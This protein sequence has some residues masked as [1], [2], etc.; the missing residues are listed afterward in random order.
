MVR[1]TSDAKQLEFYGDRAPKFPKG[2]SH[3]TKNKNLKE[4]VVREPTPDR[5]S[6][7]HGNVGKN[8]SET[9]SSDMSKQD[10]SIG[11]GLKEDKNGHQLPALLES[12]PK[13]D[14]AVGSSDAHDNAGK[15]GIKEEVLVI[16][17]HKHGLFVS[18]LL[19][20]LLLLLL[21]RHFVGAL[22]CV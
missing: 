20:L 18:L 13:T 3:S 17:L 7:P 1:P 4:T 9:L 11:T 15:L 6:V 10:L 2:E 22:N 5:Y 12:S 21:I 8:S 19:L 16:A 14:D